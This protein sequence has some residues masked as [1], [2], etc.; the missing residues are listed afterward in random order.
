MGNQTSVAKT[1]VTL[2]LEQ[3]LQN[4]GVEYRLLEHEPVFTSEQAATVRGTP[5]EAGAKALVVKAGDQF[6]VAVLPGN[7]KVN[8]RRLRELLGT[9]H[10]RFVDK[11]ELHELTGCVP[12]A[13]PPFGNLFG[14][15]VVMDAALR[16]CDEVAFNAGSNSVSIIMQREDFERLSGAQVCEFTFGPSEQEAN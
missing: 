10:L 1:S 2:R 3:L 12:G 9:R 4:A 13:V 16:S 6:V 5:P 11:E 15:P 8:N 14:L 7:R